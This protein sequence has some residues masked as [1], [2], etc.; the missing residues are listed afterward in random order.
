MSPR[1]RKKKFV[2]LVCSACGN[3][4]Q[5]GLREHRQ[6]IAQGNSL[7]FCSVFC[8]HNLRFAG[9]EQR[10]CEY[11]GEP[12]LNPRFCSTSCSA[13]RRLGKQ[14][15]PPIARTCQVCSDV[16]Y[17]STVH[18]SR[19]YCPKCKGSADWLVISHPRT[20]QRKGSIS[21]TRP[22]YRSLTIAQAT[23]GPYLK[24]KHRSHITIYI[25]QFN[26]AWNKALLFLP[27]AACG[28]SKHVQLAHIKPVSSFPPEATIG[29][30]NSPRNVIQLCPN[31]HWEFDHGLLALD[32]IWSADPDSNGNLKSS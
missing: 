8:S 10:A 22:A 17:C 14:N 15:N 30:V 6:R 7:T 25:R 23:S 13:S 9:K 26:R 24:G 32:N 5:R 11:C 12:T 18:R 19:A 20:Q 16:F 4:F 31:C 27:C 3:G 1:G 29:E 21:Y 28:Y 2:D